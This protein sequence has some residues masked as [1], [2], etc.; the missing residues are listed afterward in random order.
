MVGNDVVDIAATRRRAR[1]ARFD[2]R[3]F[4]E[5]ERR[6]IAADADGEARRW[7]HWAAKESAYKIA[8]RADADTIFSPAKFA[9]AFD[10]G[11]DHGRDSDLSGSVRYGSTSYP[12]QVQRRGDCIHAVAVAPGGRPAARGPA[13]RAVPL[14]G[15]YARFAR[16]LCLLRSILAGV[17]PAPDGAGDTSASLA[18]RRL[19]IRDLA[20]RLATAASDLVVRSHERIPRLQHRDGHDVATLSLSHHGR[21]VAY[22]CR[23]PDAAAEAAR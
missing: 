2:A 10:G 1:N 12:V 14:C 19:A 8:K 22:A 13:L 5:R 16:D 21:F 11:F 9:V 4:S 6:A 20:P 7:A 23:L 17:G 15:T 3:V 18:V